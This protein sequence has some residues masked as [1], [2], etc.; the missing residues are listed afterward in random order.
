[1]AD[2]PITPVSKKPVVPV[3]VKPEVVKPVVGETA[4]KE[5]EW[6]RI[7]NFPNSRLQEKYVGIL[8]DV[9][10][11]MSPSLRRGKAEDTLRDLLVELGYTDVVRAY[12]LIS[13]S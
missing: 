5:G 2:K 4:P 7:E 9:A 13:K 8:G 12:D 3:S 1:M 10:T 6:V 11:E